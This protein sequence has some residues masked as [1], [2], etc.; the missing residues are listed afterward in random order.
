M[1]GARVLVLGGTAEARLL[2]DALVAAGHD[3]LL[4]L[5]GRTG[6]PASGQAPLRSGGFGGPEGLAAFLR[7]GRFAACIDATHPFAARMSRNAETG[8]AA[9][10]VPRLAL[11]RSPWVPVDGD[12]WIEVDDTAQAARL[13]PAMGKRIFVAFADG[14]AP[15][16]AL[17][18]EFV[19][20]RAEPGPA[21]GLP[22]AQVIVQRGPFA[23]EAERVLLRDLRVDALV[24]KASG[25]EG[26]RAK[27]DAAR[28]LGLP[29]VLLRR[30]AP[31]ARPHA[32][33]PEEALA[34]LHTILG[35][36]RPASSS[37]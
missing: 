8:C 29:V 4:S 24:A 11:L 26:A 36:D 35:L 6:A 18:L 21:P 3:A 16:A 27:L 19:V 20:R 25:G 28:N 17:D 13:L 2:A 23:R 5:A 32:A 1:S 10:G 33:T 14:L 22:G 7:E 34:W 37:V 12:R 30:P 15:F 9:A 31:P